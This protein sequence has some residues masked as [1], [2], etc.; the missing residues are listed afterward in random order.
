MTSDSAF[1]YFEI[2]MLGMFAAS[3]LILEWQGK[4][5]DKKR[6]AEK[7]KSETPPKSN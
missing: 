3:W 6:E 1:N 5:L 7:A 2:L 4:R